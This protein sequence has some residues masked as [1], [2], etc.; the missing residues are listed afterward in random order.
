MC[1]MN[2]QHC[3]EGPELPWR[4]GSCFTELLAALCVVLP[5]V[6]ALNSCYLWAEDFSHWLFSLSCSAGLVHSAECEVVTCSNGKC[7]ALFPL[8]CLSPGRGLSL[9]MQQVTGF[10]WSANSAAS[11]S[12]LTQL[13]HKPNPSVLGLSKALSYAMPKL[14]TDRLLTTCEAVPCYCGKPDH[15]HSLELSLPQGAFA[16]FFPYSLLLGHQG[17]C[18]SI[19]WRGNQICTLAQ[20]HTHYSP[21]ISLSSFSTY[22]WALSKQKFT[23]CRSPFLRTLPL[24]QCSLKSIHPTITLFL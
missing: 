1:P 12:I 4:Q 9:L 20:P 14:Q 8:R 23:P 2:Q 22:C 10:L 15:Y 13:M 3:W 11:L 24:C 7:T 18:Q 16:M 21:P 6:H 17:L 5:C 19:K